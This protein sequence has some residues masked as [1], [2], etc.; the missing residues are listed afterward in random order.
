MSTKSVFDS[1]PCYQSFQLEINSC[2]W[3][4]LHWHFAP[5]LHEMSHSMFTNKT[6]KE[7]QTTVLPLHGSMAAQVNIWFLFFLFSFWWSTWLWK[8]YSS[9]L[10]FIVRDPVQHKP[11]GS[12]K[13]SFTLTAA[14]RELLRFCGVGGGFLKGAESSFVDSRH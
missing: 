3:R 7:K 14:T 9:F 10:I 4:N 1:D 5:W 6:I 12:L 2:F 8:V 11:A 13:Q